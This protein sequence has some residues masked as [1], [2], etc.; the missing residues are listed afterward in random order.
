MKKLPSVK[1]ICLAIIVISCIEFM[2]NRLE[3][4]T[5]LSIDS[6]VT[7]IGNSLIESIMLKNQKEKFI[8]LNRCFV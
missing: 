1:A 6:T 2:T 5:V 3:Q 7:T 8:L 4:I